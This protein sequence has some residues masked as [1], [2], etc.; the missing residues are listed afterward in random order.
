MEFRLCFREEN[1]GW[2]F[3]CTEEASTLTRAIYQAIDRRGYF[4][5]RKAGMVLKIYLFNEISNEFFHVYTYYRERYFNPYIIGYLF[6]Q[7]TMKCVKDK[8]DFV[9]SV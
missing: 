1:K 4:H 6:G 3:T 2:S 7:P 9:L 5:N 8:G